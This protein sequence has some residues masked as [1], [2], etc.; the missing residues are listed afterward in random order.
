MQRRWQRVL[1]DTT[2][3]VGISRP[4][5][6]GTIMDHDHAS[7]FRPLLEKNVPQFAGWINT[8]WDSAPDLACHNDLAFCRIGRALA[9]LHSA[10]DC[11][12][13]SKGVL[14]LGEAGAGK[15]HLLMRVARQLGSE[16]SICF[17]RRP[18]NEEAVAQHIWANVV[19]S[20]TRVAD[21]SERHDRSQLDELLAHVFRYV[22]VTEFEKDINSGQ[23]ATLKQRWIKQLKADPYAVF[24]L[25][26][27]GDKR[28]NDLRTIRNRTLRYLQLKHPEVDQRIAHALLT[29][30]LS[31]DRSRRRAV[32]TWLSGR[33][34]DDREATSLG[35]PESWL[36]YDRAPSR[37][38]IRQHREDQALRGI[39]T[40]GVLSIY[41]RPIILAFDQLEGLRGQC[42][43][44]TAWGDVVREI[45]TMTPNLL[46]VTCVF[47][48][49]W[50]KWFSPRL[51]A[52][53]TQR[54]SEHVVR[55]EPLNTR[56]ARAL[57]EKHLEANARSLLL[58]SCIYP[59]TEEDI[60][61]MSAD[62]P[63]P[64]KFLD[65]VRSAFDDWLEGTHDV[66]TIS[67][68]QKYTKVSRM[69]LL[70]QLFESERAEYTA[71][72][73]LW[74]QTDEDLF[75]RVC[76]VIRT[77]FRGDPTIR[78]S[79]ARDGHFVMPDNVIIHS[80][81]G[82]ALCVALLNAIGGAFTAR[83][84]HFA[85]AMKQR[86][87]FRYAI[88]MRNNNLRSPSEQGLAFLSAYKKGRG[89]YVEMDASELAV[90]NALY[91]TIVAI[92]ERNPYQNSGDINLAD[93]LR[94]VVE[95][96]MALG[97]SCVLNEVHK[98]MDFTS[99]DNPPHADENSRCAEHALI[100]E[101]DNMPTD[102][103]VSV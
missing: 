67:P 80:K 98:R 4:F 28:V 35:L 48:S 14:V 3:R 2:L 18:N 21:D 82:D 85:E 40:L 58:P 29:Y 46:V 25:L 87:Q 95:T 36:E 44:T 92:E 88:L 30:C 64:R 89:V 84:K 39:Q 9:R 23:Q 63:T 103:P 93:F 69:V 12:P 42:N 8:P 24:A 5:N 20:L 50:E 15:T 54:L 41:H 38:S 59:F 33:D 78:M 74:L 31:A 72:R 22:L 13:T 51:D 97:Q 83:M 27:D 32:L 56:N 71:S 62:S 37:M 17:V 102:V 26:G 60:R 76:H 6:A 99:Q 86:E 16:N 10:A 101:S 70:Q 11:Q 19:D 57:L 96:E 73:A 90:L 75:G 55:L 94:F 77:L 61:A 45:F 91:D 79:V 34:I 43:L 100:A 52:S 53:A 66:P 1:S 65:R 7:Q 68:G 81:Y 49:H 47:R